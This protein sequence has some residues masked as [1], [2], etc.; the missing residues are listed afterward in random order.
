[1]LV[2]GGGTSL[3]IVEQ[4]L[5]C[6][7]RSLAQGLSALLDALEED[8][9]VLD[10]LFAY[11]V[12]VPLLRESKSPTM[13]NEGI[14]LAIMIPPSMRK[15]VSHMSCLSL[16][17]PTMVLGVVLLMGWTTNTYLWSTWM[18]MA[19]S[20]SVI[21]IAFPLAFPNSAANSGTAWCGENNDGLPITCTAVGTEAAGIGMV[22]GISG[23]SDMILEL[24]YLSVV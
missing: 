22:G 4:R 9:H 16:G 20:V 23:W 19:S 11:R 15:G 14:P 18:R 3:C 2:D 5:A 17:Q 8:P 6:Q 7:L 24:W 1:M 21:M 12:L 13:M 10:G